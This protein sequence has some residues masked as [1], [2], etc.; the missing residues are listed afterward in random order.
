MK[1][2]NKRI[3][4]NEIIIN[5]ASA[6]LKFQNKDGSFP[7]GHNGPWNSNDTPVRTTSHWAILLLKANKLTNDIKFKKSAT[8]AY[9]YLISKNARPFDYAFHCINSTK[10][11]MHS[12]G[13]IGQAWVIESLIEAYK[14]LNDSVYLNLAE[15]LILKHKFN[16]DLYLWNILGLNGEILK[17]HRTFNQQL[18]FSIMAF[19]VVKMC[20]NND[21]SLKTDKFFNIL[22]SIVKFKKFIRMHLKESYNQQ[23]ISLSKRSFTKLK[24]MLAKTYFLKLS[25]G[26][27][28]FSLFALSELYKI[29]QSMSLW[30]SYRFKKII[31]ESVKYLDDK[32]FN[33]EKNEFGFQYN[34]IGFE[35]AFIKERLSKY[36]GYYSGH[37]IEEW[38][39]KQ[40]I[41]HYDFKKMMM[42]K[43]TSDQNTLA[44]RIYELTRLE[45]RLLI[46]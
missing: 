12:N 29:D 40:L 1:K 18:W 34:P 14:Y 3:N 10:I 44:S 33:D 5:S 21:I 9:D 7:Q 39:L 17:L 11:I 35:V 42:I 26:Y 8:K 16:K 31:L 23:K 28:S 22:P 19:K 36:L 38:I 27:L 13:L 6:A 20:N 45:N 37:S 30:K 24:N 4:L 25:R 32:I 15:D 46:I 41:N 43:N 2:M